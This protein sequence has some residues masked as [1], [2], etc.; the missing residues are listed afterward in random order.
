[1]VGSVEVNHRHLFPVILKQIHRNNIIDLVCCTTDTNLL[2][3][4]QFPPKRAAHILQSSSMR[5]AV[6]NGTSQIHTYL[7]TCWV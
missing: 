1:M 2:K 3:I 4:L 5:N 7:C 6:I